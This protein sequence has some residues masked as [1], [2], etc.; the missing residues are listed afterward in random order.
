VPPGLDDP[1]ARNGWRR[2]CVVR[3]VVVKSPRGSIPV[4][5]RRQLSTARTGYS[6]PPARGPP[7]SQDPL[8]PTFPLRTTP[9]ARAQLLLNRL[10]TARCHQGC[11]AALHNA[12]RATALRVRASASGATHHRRPLVL[13]HV[14]RDLPFGIHQYAGSL[15]LHPAR[16]P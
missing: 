11:G 4:E 5:G 3:L 9:V 14:E 2:S 10:T 1:R 7:T 8:R 16:S 6:S 12:A 13:G 15:P